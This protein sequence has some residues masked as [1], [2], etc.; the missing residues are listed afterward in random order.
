M[1][2]EY[3]DLRGLDETGR[4]RRETLEKAGMSELISKLY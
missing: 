4:P 3:Y 1:L 2:R